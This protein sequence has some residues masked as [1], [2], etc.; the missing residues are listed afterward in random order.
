MRYDPDA[1]LL[2]TIADLAREQFELDIVSCH[3]L[4]LRRA[5]DDAQLAEGTQEERC[6]VT[7]NR[8][9]FLLWND[10]VRE[11]GGAHR[12]ILITTG[13]VPINNFYVVARALALYHDIYPQPFTP[14]LVD[15]L[16]EA[17]L[18]RQ[19]SAKQ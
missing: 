3:D 1:D 17:P 2:P 7:N 11:R 10:R 12:G 16:H 6:I 19:R 5:H 8:D 15:W 14:N 4:G 18:D 9:D 13:T